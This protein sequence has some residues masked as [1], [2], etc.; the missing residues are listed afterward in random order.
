M[1]V[2]AYTANSTARSPISNGIEIHNCR[3]F[4]HRVDICDVR[5]VSNFGRR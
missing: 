5:D 3:V 1:H 2:C 4:V